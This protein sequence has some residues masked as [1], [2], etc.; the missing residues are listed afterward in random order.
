MYSFLPDEILKEILTPALQ[1]SDASF[2]CIGSNSPFSRYQQS[3]S[4]YLLVCKDWLRVA[5]PL[6][7]NVV[8]LRS[9]A[10]MQALER[11]LKSTKELGGFIKK[12]RIESGHCA[13]LQHILKAAQNLTD[14]FLSFDIYSQD[15]V[16]GLCKGLQHIQ[17]RRAIFYLSESYGGFN[18]K[19]E[20]V[21]SAL[22]TLMPKW[23]KLTKVVVSIGYLGTHSEVTS[24][25]LDCVSYS[26]DFSKYQASRRLYSKGIV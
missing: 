9:K 13:S 2:A 10:Q 15:T 16:L 7:Y 21:T 24:S 14:L 26:N 6:L 20:Q 22:A 5:T 18:Q 12:L 3:T 1:I 25:M 23:T 11:A 19:N 17:P 4:A 8:I